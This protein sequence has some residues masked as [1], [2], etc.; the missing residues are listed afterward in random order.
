MQMYGK[1]EKF[2]HKMHC[3]GWQ[4]CFMPTL[5]IGVSLFACLLGRFMLCPLLFLFF[6]YGL[7]LLGK[8]QQHT[9]LKINMDIWM[10]L[11]WIYGY[12]YIYGYNV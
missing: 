3:L 4:L 7:G 12:I 1:F 9:P 8:K 11:T 6:K 2:P 5:S 10:Y